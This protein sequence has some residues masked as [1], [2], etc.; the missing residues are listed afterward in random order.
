[1]SDIDTKIEDLTKLINDLEFKIKNLEISVRNLS[2]LSSDHSG[3][4][5]PHNK[6]WEILYK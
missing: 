3:G 1:M 5:K 6:S 4:I 2:S